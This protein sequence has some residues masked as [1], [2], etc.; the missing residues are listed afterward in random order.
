VESHYAIECEQELG[1]AVGAG[2]SQVILKSLRDRVGGDGGA[3]V[4]QGLDLSV[5]LVGKCRRFWSEVEELCCVANPL[6][7]L[8]CAHFRTIAVRA[9]APAARILPSILSIVDKLLRPEGEVLISFG[10][11]WYHPLGG[12]LFS[13]FPWRI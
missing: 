10:P 7:G 11:T 5:P 6:V 12:D 4:L 8:S 13:A 2:W 9:I 1:Q 3:S